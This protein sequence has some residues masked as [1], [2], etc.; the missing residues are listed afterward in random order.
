MSEMMYLIAAKQR[1]RGF[2]FILGK[3]SDWNSRF[4]PTSDI[5]IMWLTHQVQ[6]SAIL[7]VTVMS[8]CPA[9]ISI[10][11]LGSRCLLFSSHV[12]DSGLLNLF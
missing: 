1:Y 11:W 8:I 12:L 5:L 7:T 9:S 4:V 2:L 10:I 3:L 6:I